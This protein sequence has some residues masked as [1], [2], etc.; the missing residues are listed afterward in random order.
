MNLRD[1]TRLALKLA[2]LYFLVTTIVSLIVTAGTYVFT[3]GAKWPVWSVAND[4]AYF[5]IGAALFWFP[6]I[7]VDCVVRVDVEGPV[8]TPR[9]LEVGLGLLG[10]YFALQAA[11]GFIYA[12]ARAKWFYHL[13]DTLGRGTAPEFRPD[14]L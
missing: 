3:P 6:G 7:V 1:I 5:L 11:Y 2:G 10:V 14:D 13:N 9:L 4:A 12:V 8:T